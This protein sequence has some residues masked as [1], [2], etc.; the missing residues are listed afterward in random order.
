MRNLKRQSLLVVIV[1]VIVAASFTAIACARSQQPS[2]EPHEVWHKSGQGF[3]AVSRGRL[4]GSTARRCA[5]FG[6]S[7]GGEAMAWPHH[8]AVRFDPLRIVVAASGR[9]VA[10]EG[11]WIRTVGGSTSKTVAGCPSARG[12]WFPTTIEFWGNQRPP[13]K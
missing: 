8:Y 6:D 3:L 9:V 4:Y 7:S 1:I 10:R 13:L 12:V 2:R 5:W 11:D